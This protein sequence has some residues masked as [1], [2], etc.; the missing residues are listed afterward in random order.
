MD[1]VAFVNYFAIK[2][3]IFW[4]FQVPKGETFL[5]VDIL[6]ALVP[7]SCSSLNILFNSSCNVVSKQGVGIY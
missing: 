1:P 2:F 4:N 7:Q 6:D 5:S 3:C